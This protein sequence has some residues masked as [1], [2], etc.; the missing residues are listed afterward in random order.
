MENGVYSVKKQVDVL[1][2]GAGP[3]GMQA[4]I[5]ASKHGVDV[6]LVDEQPSPGGQ[7]WRAVEDSAQKKLEGILGE[8]YCA[9]ASIAQSFRQSR[10][11]Y[12]PLTQ[13][14]Q[15]EA[16]KSGWQVYMSHGTQTHSVLAK[17]II[18]ATGAQERPAPFPGW[19]LPG[20][21]TV[22]AAQIALKTSAEIPTEPVWI[23]GC[24]PLVLLYIHQLLNAGGKVA[25]WIDT[26]PPQKLGHK[27][28]L[29]FGALG[30]WKEIQKGRHWLKAIQAHD[31][32]I[33]KNITSFRAQGEQEL[34]EIQIQQ[35]DGRT[36]TFPAS[37]LLVHDGVVPSIH[38]TLA[39][40]C[41][42]EW[43]AQ[44]QC[45]KPKLDEWYQ[46]SLQGIYVAGDGAGILGA[47]AALV[48]GRQVGLA[49]AHKL[50]QLTK[51]QVKS[52][53]QPLEKHLNKA[54]QLRK[55]LDALYPPRVDYQ[56]LADE[57]VVCRC[58]EL[59]AKDIRA[60]LPLGTPGPNQVKSLT[61][62]GMGPCQG[63]QC[64]YTVSGLIAAA[65][66]KSI[67]EVGFYRIRPPLKP[68]TLG[69]LASLDEETRP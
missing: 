52:L 25:G 31:I 60:V 24:G 21:L 39:M 38:M 58:E 59:T 8:D 56:T 10:A 62:A 53:S 14:W 68:L 12:Q 6:L 36:K 41:E 55:L 48:Q 57:T 4:A 17:K 54:R 5:E 45:F 3:A 66:N 7:I 34:E 40:S 15:I 11:D 46:T 9:G 61:R 67:K 35:A 42:H 23:A 43:C 63:R 22:G 20:V 44:Q 30:S 16:D 33:Y 18:L 26:S 49:V 13:V 32:P 47:E 64:G 50:G 19:T 27:L 51:K 28:P 69:M 29:L 1:V 37:V 2:L 65:Q